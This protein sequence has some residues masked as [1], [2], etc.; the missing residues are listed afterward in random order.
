MGLIRSS[1]CGCNEVLGGRGGGSVLD[2]KFWDGV[3]GRFR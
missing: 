2:L 3:G 1:A